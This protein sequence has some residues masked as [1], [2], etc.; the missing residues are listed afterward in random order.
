MAAPAPQ[1][2]VSYPESV[3]LA[4]RE[5]A[6]QA[7]REGCMDKLLAAVRAIDARLKRDPRDFGEP[8]HRYQELKLVLH[9]AIHAPLVV[10]FTI[11]D[12]LPVVFVKS[13]CPLPGYGL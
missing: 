5:H 3:S 1:F 8:K 12:E 11:H 13:L 10:H 7:A 2:T 9:V 6:K 4:L